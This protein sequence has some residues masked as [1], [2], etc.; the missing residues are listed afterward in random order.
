MEALFTWFNAESIKLNCQKE[1]VGF[2]DASAFPKQIWRC[3]HVLVYC[4]SHGQ[5]PP[6]EQ[7]RRQR[8]IS[9]S[10]GYVLNSVPARVQYLLSGYLIPRAPGPWRCWFLT[11]SASVEVLEVSKGDQTPVGPSD[12]SALRSHLRLTL[13]PWGLWSL[14]GDTEGP[15]DS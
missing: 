11:S 7:G 6:V 4:Q 2:P 13:A 3:S 15:L 1:I 9:P 10:S 8:Q 14:L 5:Y 12:A